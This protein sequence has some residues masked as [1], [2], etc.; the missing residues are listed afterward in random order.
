MVSLV[1]MTQHA[2]L[3][4]LVT[5]CRSYRRLLRIVALLQDAAEKRSLHFV[6]RGAYARDMERLQAGR[7]LD[8]GNQLSRLTP[9]L[10]D[11][12]LVVGGRLQASDLPHR[13][14][15]PVI[16]PGRHHV[17]TDRKSVV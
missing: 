16:L 5:R 8:K 17:T 3:S 12:L 2:G 1:M 14:Q 10:D 13:S 9:C 11:G 4:N 15:H 6:Q 7:S